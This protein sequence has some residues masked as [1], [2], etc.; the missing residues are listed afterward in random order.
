MSGHCSNYDS[1]GRRAQSNV[2]TNERIAIVSRN[3]LLHE[4]IRCGQALAQTVPGPRTV[5]TGRNLQHPQSPERREEEGIR[6]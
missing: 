5:T 1:T 6:H 2:S 3:S 4:I